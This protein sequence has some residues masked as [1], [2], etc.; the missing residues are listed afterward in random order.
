M[1]GPDDFEL[2][3]IRYATAERTGA[4]VWI[5][6]DPHEG[7]IPM[8]YYVWVARN[9][10]HTVVIDTGFDAPAA[11]RR[12]RRLLLH[13]R[14]GLQR[15]GV[16]CASVRDVVITHLHYD[17]AGNLGLFPAARF[18]LQDAEMAYAT[19]RHMAQ[20]FF[21]HAYDVDPVLDMVRLVYGARVRFHCGDATILPGLS[22]HHVGGHTQGLQVVRVQTRS[23][24]M[25]L[26]SDAAHYLANM[27]QGR[28]FPIVADVMQMTAGWERLRALADAEELI[29]PGH[30]PLVMRRFPAAGAGL[31]DIA[32]RLD[33]GPLPN[34]GG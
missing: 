14:D 6:G 22:V 1:S 17:H 7:P 21:A 32:V 31:E 28:P 27:Q 29:I 8:D 30:D 23:G 10:Q 18:H 13:P 33:A 19:G 20:S 12:G 11:Q 2:Y 3:A 5:G 25:V 34:A 15:L 4:E 16:D 26:A 9:A 24:W